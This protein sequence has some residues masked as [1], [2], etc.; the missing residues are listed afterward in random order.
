MAIILGLFGF[1]VIVGGAF[2]A[3]AVAGIFHDMT[4]TRLDEQQRE[5]ERGD[6]QCKSPQSRSRPRNSLFPR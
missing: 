1:L 2:A 3:F 4:V 6:A 5:A